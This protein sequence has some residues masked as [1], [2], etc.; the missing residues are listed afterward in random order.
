MLQVLC[1]W[2][3]YRR[4]GLYIIQNCPE[5]IPSECCSV[6]KFLI[7]TRSFV[8]SK[9]LKALGTIRAGPIKNHSII[10]QTTDN[11]KDIDRH[12]MQR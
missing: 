6:V 11:E 2:A 4:L 9:M 1:R 5:L 8:N 10:G 12:G 3:S 7:N